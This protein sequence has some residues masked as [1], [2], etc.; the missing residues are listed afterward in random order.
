MRNTVISLFDFTG[1][2]VKPW[3]DAGFECW[4]LDIQHPAAHDSGGVTIED[5]IHRLHFDLSRPWLYPARRDGIAIVFA[6]PP[7]DHLAVSGSR[8]MKGKGLRALS[9]AVQFFA[10]A[11]EFCEW[12][13][14]AYMIENPVSTI[15]TYWRKPDFTFHPY[16][17]TAFCAADNYTKATC[18]WTGNGFKMP[19]PNRKDLGKP[20]DRVHKA[21]PG[22][23]RKNFRSATPM[24]FAHAVFKANAKRTGQGRAVTR[25]D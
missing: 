8:W 9:Q 25:C 5:G 3:R 20:D 6:F 10:S 4:T 16:L 13:G 14:A 15:S 18:L 1:N 21:P 12:S 19:K 7:C 23:E 17:Y 2:M 24:G 11:I 22:K